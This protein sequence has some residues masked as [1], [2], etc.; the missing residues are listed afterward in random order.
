MLLREKRL[1]VIC[2]ID[3]TVLDI[4]HRFHLLDGENT[5]WEEFLS[6]D[7]VRKDKPMWNTIDVISCLATRYPIIFLTGRNEGTRGITEE[8]I[9]SMWRCQPLLNGYELY[10][11][12]DGDYRKDTEIKKEMYEKYIEPNYDVLAAFDDKPDIVELWRDLGLTAYHVGILA[13][14]DG[15]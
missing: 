10:M 11:R 4:T 1:V 6:V 14:G 13:S 12:E 15:F 7:N 8:Q 5:N 2:D 3:N 9:A